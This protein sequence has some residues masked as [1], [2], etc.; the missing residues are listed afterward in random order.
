MSVR[1]GRVVSITDAAAAAMSSVV[2]VFFC[3][4][5]LFQLFQAAV[6][7]LDWYRPL[8]VA[9]V[10]LFGLSVIVSGLA[11]VEHFT[12]PAISTVA[13]PL[14]FVLALL[15]G[16]RMQVVLAGA[17]LLTN[18][19]VAAFTY[20]HRAVSGASRSVRYVVLGHLVLSAAFLSV[21]L[22]QGKIVSALAL[23]VG[24]LI[25]L[26]FVVAC[27][28]KMP[29]GLGAVTPTAAPPSKASPS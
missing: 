10:I 23:I 21:T 24:V 19:A 15:V 28:L 20:R 6:F 29:S 14:F 5:A 27:V 18:T 3:L 2:L 12:A 4:S 7:S 25:G 17:W 8:I 11:L 22:I 26:F 13:M 9:F 16:P 1:S